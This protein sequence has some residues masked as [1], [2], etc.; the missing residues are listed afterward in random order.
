VD[1][2]Y[3]RDDPAAVGRALARLGVDPPP[4]FV[5]FHERS[6]G[7]IGSSRSAYE[8][9]DLAD[10]EPDYPY[11]PKNPTVVGSTELV[12]EMFGLPHQFLVISSYEC[13]AVLVYDTTTDLV[14]NV[15]F[16]GGEVDLREGLLAPSYPSFQALLDDFLDPDS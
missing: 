14:Y 1:P 9:L 12:R 13:N 8:L 5:A 7:V 6:A 11:D 10:G 4:G 3:R 15:D 2:R 16:E